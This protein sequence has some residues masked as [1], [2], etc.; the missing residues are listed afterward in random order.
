ME[1]MEN[2]NHNTDETRIESESYVRAKRKMESLRSFYTHLAI[3]IIINSFFTFREVYELVQEGFT[4]K[5][6]FL[7]GDIYTLWLV[8]GF[9]LIIHGF[10]VFSSIRIFN[11]KWEQRK[12][13][14]YMKEDSQ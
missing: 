4:L 11:Y 8:W 6:A 3:Y 13:E 9:G 2:A 5:E 14:Q 12:I 7:D 10:N 1:L